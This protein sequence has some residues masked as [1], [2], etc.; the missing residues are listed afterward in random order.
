MK[1]EVPLRQHFGEWLADSYSWHLLSTLTYDLDRAHRP[2][3]TRGPHPERAA[4]DFRWWVGQCNDL[5]H[6]PRWK[7][8]GIPGLQF[9]A[10]QELQ[11]RGVLHHHAVMGDPTVDLS[12]YDKASLRAD[13]KNLWYRE[14]GIAQVEAPR[15]AEATAIYVCKYVI[16]DGEYELS[17]ELERLRL[18]QALPFAARWYVG[19]GALV[20]AQV[21]SA[22][23]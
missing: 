11:R 10:S 20:R 6:G 14:N 18:V 12:T 21:A 22:Q 5:M 7:R 23:A 19:S 17:A 9:C 4:K 2:L 15:D 16:K 13:F 3:S 8:R 1:V